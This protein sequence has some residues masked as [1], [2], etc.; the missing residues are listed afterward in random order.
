MR[1]IRYTAAWRRACGNLPGAL[2]HPFEY[3]PGFD[4]RIE[5]ELD[6]FCF[7]VAV[8]SDQ[9]RT[10]IHLAMATRNVSPGGALLRASRLFSIPAPLPRTVA[11]QSSTTL[12]NS[13]TATQPYPTH[14]TI[15]TPPSSLA[16]G[17]WGLKRPL[18]LRS[19][20][21]TSTPLLRVESVDTIE[22]ITE[23]SSAADHALTLQKWQE[24]NMPMSLPGEEGFLGGPR[25]PGLGAFEEILYTTSSDTTKPV[26]EENRWKFG[27]PWLAG[28]TVGEFNDFVR[29]TIRA[30]K[31]EFQMFLKETKALEDTKTAQQEAAQQGQNPPPAV[32]ASDI[33]D[34][35]LRMYIK[36]LRQDRAALF[37]LIR[38]FLDLPPAPVSTSYIDS[39]EEDIENGLGTG[40]RSKTYTLK[41]DDFLSDST[42]PYAHSGPP[43]THPSAG[44]SYL[45][46]NTYI[47]NHPIYGPQAQ[48]PP[49][50]GRIIQPRGAFAPKLGI[51][52]VVTNT[53]FGDRYNTKRPISHPGLLKI[54]PDVVGGSK[55][56][57]RPISATIDNSGRIDLRVNSGEGPALAVLLGKEDQT[58]PGSRY[59]K[60]SYHPL[61]RPPKTTQLGYG[62]E[63][64][65]LT[66]PTAAV[67]ENDSY[68]KLTALLGNANSEQ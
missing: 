18:P 61:P 58:I 30:R 19:T 50:E 17:D 52:G 34:T 16:R 56:Y 8:V 31:A 68:K 11:E 60:R 35:Q 55:L 21:N 29:K 54:E 9:N 6:S 22:H 41:S 62:L 39:L 15:T 36:E 20:T 57:L 5:V 42:S 63:S 66:A 10:P 28:L 40:N 27:G 43:K 48:P 65:Q 37:R 25:K 23:Y 1:I 51:A 64:S 59:S 32:N 3:L 44:L 14:L 26:A 2:S 24:L 12:Y 67:D 53:P 13:D 49:I 47:F 7:E 33:T 4:C 46:S 45:R 38:R